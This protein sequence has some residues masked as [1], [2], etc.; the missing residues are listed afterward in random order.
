M[1]PAVV[2]SGRVVASSALSGKNSRGSSTNLKGD[3]L[4]NNHLHFNSELPRVPGR[5]AS[6]VC[7]GA[8]S[9]GSAHHRGRGKLIGELCC[10]WMGKAG[11]P[12]LLHS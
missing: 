10:V 8:A 4:G 6:L 5:R 3:S 12:I 11:R 7:L 1:H 2:T 9:Q